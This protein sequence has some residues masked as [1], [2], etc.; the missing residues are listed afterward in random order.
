MAMIFVLGA[1]T[2]MTVI[3]GGVLSYA[4]N[5]QPAARF[6]EDWTAALAAAQSGVDDYVAKLNKSD[7][8]ARSVDCTNVALR[9]PKAETNNCN[10]NSDTEPGWVNVKPGVSTAGQFHYDVN[11]S[12]FWKN[13]SVW[14]E[15]TGRVGT[16]SRTIQVRVYRGGSTEF[17]YYTDFEDADPQNKVSYPSGAPSN[18]CGLS[19]ATLAKYWWQTRSGCSEIQFAGFDVLDGKVH[20][21]D[22]PLMSNNGGTRPRFLQGFETAD[23]NCTEALGKADASG[24]GTNA[25]KGKCWRSTSTVNPYVG[26]YG[27]TPAAPLYLP[28]NS[29]QFVNFPGCVFTGDTRIKFN[30]NGT[31]DVWNTRSAGTTLLGPDT[32]AGTNCGNASQFVANANGQP[33]AKQN[34]PVPDDMV[35]YVKDATSGIGACTPGQIV[36]GTSSGSTSTDVIPQGT[37]TTVFGVTDVTFFNPTSVTSTTAIRSYSR[38]SSTS[39]TPWVASTPATPA[40]TASGDSRLSTFD[41]GQGNVYLEGTVNSHVTIAAQNNVVITGDLLVQGAAAG[42]PPAG[43]FLTG[44]VAGNSVVVYH[45]VSRASSGTTTAVVPNPS[46]YTSFCS[47][48]AGGTPLSTSSSY[49]RGPITC[50]WTSTNTFGSSY[51]DLNYPNKTTSSGTRWIYA[52]L[53]TLQRSFWVHSYDKGSSQG[54]LSVRGSIAQ[55]WRGAVGTSGGTGYQKDYSYDARLQFASPPYFPQWTN[56]AWG[57]KTTGEV[58]AAYK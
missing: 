37:G 28:D 14:L 3:V 5:Q 50:T 51:S 21:N 40:T 32:P 4:V 48:T 17:L 57:A 35:I 20:F 52:S 49:G 34:I 45:P 29:D 9:G 31:M 39:G 13:G 7:S 30:A 46:S 58:T 6:N 1:I 41:C 25:G 24:V 47:T 23:P 11:T 8:Y 2:V 38:A 18:A 27:A 16:A 36:N 12:E 55:K 42:Q 56:A 22:T 33:T 15:S 26:Q 54:K 10:W 44:L 43:P 53:Q 19:G